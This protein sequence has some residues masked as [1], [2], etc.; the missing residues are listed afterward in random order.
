M[1]KWLLYNQPQKVASFLPPIQPLLE[2]APQFATIC[3]LQAR[4]T[5]PKL[6][7]IPRTTHIHLTHV[8][9]VRGW[10]ESQVP[11][12]NVHNVHVGA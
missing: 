9:G 4:T 5:Q 1:K 11:W 12:C 8:A 2:T 7:T 6:G 10:A 3:V